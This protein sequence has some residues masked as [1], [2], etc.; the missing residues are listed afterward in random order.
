MSINRK[1]VVALTAEYGGDWAVQ[2]AHRLI[3]LVEMVGE[4]LDYDPE[5]IWLAAHMHD[6]GT[7]PRW[8]REGV[9][10]SERS[11]QLAEEHLRK[12]K[13]PKPILEKVLETIEYHHGGADERCVEALLL[14]D[15]DALDGI[16]AVGVLREFAMVPAEWNGCYSI[17]TGWGMRGAYERVRMRLENN[18]RIVRLP[19]SRQLARRRAREMRRILNAFEEESFGFI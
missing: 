10:H 8:A 17:P 18:P 7:L 5:A 13:C 16:G 15:A 3:R 9:T 2:H 6:W 14:R 19:K 11:R 1:R 4:G 12:W